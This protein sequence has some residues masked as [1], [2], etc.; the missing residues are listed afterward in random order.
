MR[1]LSSGPRCGPGEIQLPKVQPGSSIIPGKVNPL[2]PE[3]VGQ[4]CDI[5]IGNDTIVML[6]N[7]NA[8]LELN[9]FEPIMIYAI[10]ESIQL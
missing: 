4:V 2:T 5:V 7:E 10:F 6:G 9:V 3:I 8:Q 1:L